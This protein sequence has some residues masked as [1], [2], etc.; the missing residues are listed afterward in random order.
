MQTLARCIVVAVLVSSTTP[1]CESEQ[2]LGCTRCCSVLF[3]TP[4]CDPDH[5][6]RIRVNGN[7]I[8]GAMWDNAP[9]AAI[10]RTGCLLELWDLRNQTGW[11]FSYILEHLC[12]VYRLHR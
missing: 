5:A 9:V 2:L 10:V 1:N 8:L 3:S 11:C 12:M 7:G 4:D 6:L